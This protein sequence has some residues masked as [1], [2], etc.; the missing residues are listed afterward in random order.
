M[1]CSSTIRSKKG[2]ERY[3]LVDIVVIAPAMYSP[4]VGSEDTAS[5]VG[6]VE[7]VQSFLNKSS[8]ETEQA[9]NV[10][11]GYTNGL[12][13]RV[14]QILRFCETVIVVIDEHTS[15]YKIT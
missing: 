5:Y 3:K 14:D 13:M 1:V 15:V 8:E 6:F 7:T 4:L 11:L 2:D 10:P 9:C 12:T